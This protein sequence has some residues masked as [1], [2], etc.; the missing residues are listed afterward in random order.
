MG[1]PN[2]S[3]SQCRR[4]EVYSWRRGSKPLHT[5]IDVDDVARGELSEVPEPDEVEIPAPYAHR[6]DSPSGTLVVWKKC[7]RID[8]DAKADTLVRDLRSS[9]GRIFRYFLIR[10]FNQTINGTRV[11]PFDPLYLMPQARLD[12][13]SLATKHGET[14]KFELPIPGKPDQTSV[15]EVTF[16]LLPE[17]WHTKYSDTKKKDQ[18]RGNHDRQIDATAG[19]SI[20]RA[21]RE[22][23]LIASPYRKAHHL[24]RWYRVEIRFEP[25]LDEMFGVTHTKQHARIVPGT[26]LSNR[27]ESIIKANETT[28]IDTIYGWTQRAA[29]ARDSGPS[30]AEEIA[31]RLA[32]QLKPVEGL[33]EKPASEVADEIAAFVQERVAAG[34][35]PEA[36]EQLDT[37]LSQCPVI[38][39]LEQLPGAPLYR[40]RTVGQTIV[41]MLNI[42][43]PFYGRV[44]QRLE[45]DSPLGKTGVDLLL[46]SL[47]RSEIVGSDEA[48]EWYDAQRQEW[49]QNLKVFTSQLPEPD[50][51]SGK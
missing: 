9:L 37:R 15:V 12:G 7:D 34:V 21:W 16:S 46:M 4:V 1:L 10:D 13:D 8:H 31:K 23:D 36:V 42:E 27:M 35:P 28:L 49:S 51:R 41:V 19:F 33:A 6:T 50:S 24:H 17:E 47:A 30:R 40:T 29:A 43:H 44:Y 32:G 5:Y 20:V 22:I 3:V 18:K 2:A 25:E 14:L 48:R 38:I 45:Q 39:E 11:G 26:D